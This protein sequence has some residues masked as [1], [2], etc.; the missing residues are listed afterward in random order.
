MRTPSDT[1]AAIATAPGG[2]IGII[3]LSGP[4]AREIAAKHF[5]P[6]PQELS[7]RRFVIG[8]WHDAEGNR[9]D[10]GMAVG[11]EGPRSYTGEDV[12]EL[13][14]HGGA[15]NLARCLRVCLTAGARPAEPGEFTRRAFLNGKMD[16][17]RA[18]AVADMIAAST[19]Q[20]LVHARRHLE[21]RLYR[22]ANTLRER[23][24]ALAAQVEVNI[25]F[26][27]E[28][29]PVIDPHRLGSDI[30]EV[31]DT[32]G[33]L[34]ATFTEGRLLREGARVVISGPPNAGK[35]TL[36]NALVGQ[37][38]AIVTPHAGTTRDVIE[39]GIDCGGVPLTLV[40]TAG[41]RETGDE[42]ERIGVD[43]ARDEAAQADLVIGVI[44][45]L[46]ARSLGQ[47]DTR[48][49]TVWV[50]TKADLTDAAP[51]PGAQAISA[52]TGQG[53]ERLREELL[54]RLGASGRDGASLVV[55]RERHRDALQI[56]QEALLRAATALEEHREPELVSVDLQDAITALS[57][58][59]GLTTI[60][61]VL[62]QLFSSFCIGK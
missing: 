53:L 47:I 62:D 59:V 42:V 24:L 51:P 2:A 19:D 30:R 48:C 36:F 3:R 6:W 54:S 60:E 8:W 14:L 37:S 43:R 45:G 5:K 38:R 50:M 17:T 22:E 57:E 27:E 34:L 55:S 26:V 12:V 61:D 33:R 23:I 7:A 31:S 56:T 29:V 44:D 25:D 40:D 16:L 15:T 39:A 49:P 41:I 58:L 11:M 32:I 10:H 13:H 28:D 46:G 1:I 21:G 4:R 20:A 35:S 9:L 52:T 18:E